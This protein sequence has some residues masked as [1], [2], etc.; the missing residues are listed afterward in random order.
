MVLPFLKTATLATYDTKAAKNFSCT[1][2]I[3]IR[4]GESFAIICKGETV[5]V[6]DKIPQKVDCHISIDPV[7]Y[8]LLATGLTTQ[9][10]PFFTGKILIIGSKPWLALR[11]LTLFRSP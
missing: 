6:E 3:H 10:K 5:I 4:T 8:F 11:L 1:Y 2:A 7:T 9:W